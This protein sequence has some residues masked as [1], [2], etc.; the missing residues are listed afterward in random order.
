MDTPFVPPASIYSRWEVDEDWCVSVLRSY[1]A[2]HGPDF[3]WSVGKDGLDVEGCEEGKERPRWG[4]ERLFS[5]GEDMSVDGRRQL[6][7]FL[8]SSGAG[9]GKGL[10]GEAYTELV[11]DPGGG[12]IGGVHGTLPCTYLPGL[13]SSGSEASAQL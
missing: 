7:L 8:V 1:Q 10:H 13:F 2:E 4:L 3:P 9:E 12:W 5:T 11:R 6:A